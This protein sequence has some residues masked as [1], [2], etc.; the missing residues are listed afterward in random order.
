[1]PFNRKL[2]CRVTPGEVSRDQ[3]VINY[4]YDDPDS[5]IDEIMSINFFNSAGDLFYYGDNHKTYQRINIRA[6]RGA[7]F[8]P[9][10]VPAKY[11]V[12]VSDVKV[13][14]PPGEARKY[15]VSVAFGTDTTWQLS[16]TTGNFINKAWHSYFVKYEGIIRF[17]STGVPGPPAAPTLIPVASK[18]K[19]DQSDFCF[20][21]LLSSETSSYIPEPGDAILGAYTKTPTFPNLGPW[22]IKLTQVGL[23]AGQPP[24]SGKKLRGY[25]KVMG[26]F[27]EFI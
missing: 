11:Q 2:L 23:T 9:P 10:D 8:D 17:D 12:V 4:F 16:T 5:T 27:C 21:T 13:T 25:F 7:P 6:Q 19:Y 24:T 14:S 20:A 18:Y 1:M 26:T 22:E 15:K 3:A